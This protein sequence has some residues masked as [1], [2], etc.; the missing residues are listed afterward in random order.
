VRSDTKLYAVVAA[1]LVV[2]TSA[3]GVGLVGADESVDSGPSPFFPDQT[4]IVSGGPAPASDTTTNTEDDAVRVGIIG[5][6]FDADHPSLSGRVGATT[7]ID[8]R[9]WLSRPDSGKIHDTAV[10]E[11]V[12]ERSPSADLYLAAVGGNPTPEQYGS[13]VDWLLARDVDVIVD[14]GSYFPRTS[15]GLER[16]EAAASRAAE[17]GAVFVTSAG[18]YA[19][20]HWRGRPDGSG[21]LSFAPGTK[22][23]DLGNG[24]ISG[25][26]TLRLYWQGSADY[27]LYLYRDIPGGSDELV[28][29]STREEGRAEAIDTVLAKG[30]YYVAVYN[31]DGSAPVDLFAAAR[32]LEH[33]SP[34]GG[35][36]PPATAKGVVAVGAIQQGGKLQPYSSVSDVSAV[37]GIDTDVAGQF[38]GTSAATPIVAGTVSTMVA[39]ARDRSLSPSE[40]V[41]ILRE[42]ADGRLNRIDSDAA[43]ARAINETG[44]GTVDGPG[45]GTETGSRSG[46]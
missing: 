17:S 10:A 28:A 26:V 45:A 21:W 43:V 5:S 7:R 32:S 31:R 34:A 36:L 24:Q 19:Q 18:N 35:S 42:T 23:N 8:N 41:S 9:P 40:I 12:A 20:R 15:R 3:L 37:D 30:N 16:F 2:T 4:Q 14:A 33:T 1:M 22:R 39:E 38:S 46:R 13:A 11:I 6:G 25:R 27:D 44:G 29:K